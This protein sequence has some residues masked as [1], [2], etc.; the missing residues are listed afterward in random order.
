MIAA[1]KNYC[2]NNSSEKNYV[3]KFFDGYAI[4]NKIFA[5]VK[6]NYGMYKVSIEVSG[7]DVKTNCSCY[8]GKNGCHHCLALGLTFIENPSLFREIKKY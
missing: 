1:I 8:I 5:S 7:E 6:G 4:G 3:G 2:S